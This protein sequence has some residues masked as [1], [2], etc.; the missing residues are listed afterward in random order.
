MKTKF[1][2]AIL[3]GRGYVGQ[4]IIKIINN[5]PYFFISDIYS[6]TSKGKL[7]DDY[8][9]LKSLTYKLLDSPDKLDYK[10][11]DIVIMALSNNKSS[12]YVKSIEE[13][14]PNIIII[15]IS[16]DYRF[17]DRWAYKLPELAV[18][19]EKR[20][21]SNPGCY[22]S[23]IQFSLFPI[24]HLID[25]K[26]SCMGI[27]GYSGAGATPNDKNNPINLEDNI[28]PY[29]L[30][31]HIHEKEVMKHCYKDISFSPHVANFFRG[32]LITSHIKL[33][34][35]LS[36]SEIHNIY[37]TFYK[38]KELIKVIKEIPMINKVSNSH[39][40]YI[41]GFE[42]DESGYGL[43]VCCTLDNLLKGA[44]TQVIQNLNYACNL[45]ELT[46]INYE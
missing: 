5:H 23:A 46:G 13:Y 1:N 7:V 26:V 32:I 25:G 34:K 39:Y 24:K 27:S 28:I 42:V 29:S 22:A 4:E 19:D 33:T 43:T 2:I 17:D 15:D 38:G 44:A 36:N 8:T 12:D 30:S 10:N 31:G 20:R 35:K 37:Q 21:I 3:G 11:I 45:D 6:K 18:S 16:A 9:K 14:D 41:G 40:V